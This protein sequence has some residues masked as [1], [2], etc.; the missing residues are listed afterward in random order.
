[1]AVL[2]ALG[3]MNRLRIMRLLLKDQLGVS[4]I[5]HRLRMS[6]YNVSEHLRILKEAGLLEMVKSGKQR[7]YGVASRLKDHLAVN[8][9][10]LELNCCTFRFD[11]LPR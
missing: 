11:K 8:R 7:L 3:E 2:K 5:A 1:M 9:N 6:E 10:V 4:G